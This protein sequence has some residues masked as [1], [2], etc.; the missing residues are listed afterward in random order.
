M[1]T[2]QSSKVVSIKY[3]SFKVERIEKMKRMFTII[4]LLVVIAI[5]AI[6]AG[7]LLPAL[8]NARMKAKDIACRNNL[9]QIGL[10]STTY[11][12]DNDDYIVP[13]LGNSAARVQDTWVGILSGVA[14]SSGNTSGGYG[15]SFFGNTRTAGSFACPAEL[16]PFT[17]VNANANAGK[18]FAYTH[19]GVNFHL[20]G[21]SFFRKL[22]SVTSAS[23]A[24]FS[25]DNLLTVS[26]ALSN[27]KNFSYRHPREIRTMA[28]SS[29]I[30]RGNSTAN[31]VYVDGHVKP[32]LYKNLLYW[33]LSDREKASAVEGLGANKVG[34]DNQALLNG[35]LYNLR[36]V[37]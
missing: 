4:E 29:N 24:I 20:T 21:N 13:A 7:M 16:I 28:V 33:P 32:Q 17:T 2:R 36:Q 9:K 27:L 1:P 15:L 11:T 19:Y 12:M 31:F 30:P 3:N 23:D 22:A 14:D 8:N 6:L 18:G 10:A 5:I 25:G 35:F 37:R 34:P 26:Y